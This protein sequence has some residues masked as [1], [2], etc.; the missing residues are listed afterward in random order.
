MRGAVLDN[1][2]VTPYN[3]FLL[4]M[5]DSYVNVEIYSTTKVVK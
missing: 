1:C 5:F 2:D 4:A 3:P